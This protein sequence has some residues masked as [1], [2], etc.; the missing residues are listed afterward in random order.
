[1]VAMVVTCMVMLVVNCM[2]LMMANWMV[3]MIGTCKVRDG[4]LLVLDCGY[5]YC[6]DGSDLDGLDDGDL[7]SQNV[8]T[9]NVVTCI[10]CWWC[11][12]WKG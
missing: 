6:V 1:M 3:W 8:V 2:V 9:F 10:A 12:V 11:T 7:Y 5:L 4:D